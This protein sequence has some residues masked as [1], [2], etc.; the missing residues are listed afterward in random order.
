M[1]SILT[2]S[3]VARS[4]LQAGELLAYV[5]ISKVILTLSW[6]L[7]ISPFPGAINRCGSRVVLF[8]PMEL[9]GLAL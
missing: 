2:G 7:S 1:I 4:D 9:C 3:G 6:S 5:E 8:E